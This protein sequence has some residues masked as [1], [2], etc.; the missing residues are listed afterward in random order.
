MISIADGQL[1]LTPIWRPLRGAGGAEEIRL[2][3]SEVLVHHLDGAAE[4]ARAERV[5]QLDVVL[6]VAGAA[7]TRVVPP[8]QAAPQLALPRPLDRLVHPQDQLVAARGDD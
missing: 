1:Y 5:D 7:L 8:L 2:D 4:L 6:L 3:A